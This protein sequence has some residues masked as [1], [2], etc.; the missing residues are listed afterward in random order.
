MKE[1]EKM[2]TVL[3]TGAGGFL[4]GELIKQLS[5]KA[6]YRIF[7]LTTNKEKLMTRFCHI[8]KL[9]CIDMQDWKNGQLP[10]EKINTLIHCAFARGYLPVQEIA[11]SLD[12]TNDL[13]IHAVETKVNNIINISSQGV[14]GQAKKPLWDEK[15]PVAPNSIYGFAKYSSELLTSNAKKLSQDQTNTTSLRLAS[16]SGGKEGLRF[17][18]ISKFVNSALEGNPIKIIGGKQILSYLD[19]RDAAASIITLLS[20]DSGKWKEVYNLGNIPYSIVEIASLVS[21]ISKNYLEKPVKIEIEE[22]DIS[23]DVGMD[24]S[25]FYKDT[26]W[27]PQYDMKALV[28]SLFEYLN[29]KEGEWLRCQSK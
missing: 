3:V 23:L 20:I 29:H 12:F 14:Y 24:S 28:E 10:W 27:K 21:E 11:E 13:F 6:N 25:L 8:G 15:T 1:I 9:T 16:L 19:V 26:H 22:Q 18:V 17:E 7:A 5:E 2:Q 4:G